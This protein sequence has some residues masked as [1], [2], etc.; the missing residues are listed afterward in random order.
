DFIVVDPPREGLLPKALE[1][2]SGYGAGH[3]IYISCKATSLKNDLAA[4]QAAGYR[5]KRCCTVDLFPGTVH[6]ETVC[7]LTREG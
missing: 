3:V 5:V 6:V 4:L 1:K 2:V 7:L